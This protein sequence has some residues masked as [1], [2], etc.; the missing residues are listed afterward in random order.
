MIDTASPT[1]QEEP[2]TNG[3]VFFKS[4]NVF[5]QLFD[6][7]GNAP[8]PEQAEEGEASEEKPKAEGGEE[9]A[10][11]ESENAEKSKDE[12]KANEQSKKSEAEEAIAPKTDESNKEV[13]KRA[14]EKTT[15]REDEVEEIVIISA[16]SKSAKNKSDKNED[17][18]NDVVIPDRVKSALKSASGGKSAFRPVSSS[19]KSLD[20]KATSSRP[21]SGTNK[22]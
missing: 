8:D 2:P 17:D 15:A 13:E 19:K 1:P 5:T 22:E 7:V 4:L 9:T 18:D 10:A 16:K 14:D 21:Q 20:E 6:S 11:K 3:T 12:E